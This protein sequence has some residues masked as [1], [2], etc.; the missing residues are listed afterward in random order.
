MFSRACMV[1]LV[2]NSALSLAE[3][4]AKAQAPYIFVYKATTFTLTD[5]ISVGT[6]PA[7]IAVRTFCCG[8]RVRTASIALLTAFGMPEVDPYRTTPSGPTLRR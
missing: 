7:A 6:G 4:A 3:P 1:P 8:P 2:A 5:S